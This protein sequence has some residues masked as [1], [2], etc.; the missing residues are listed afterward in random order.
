MSLIEQINELFNLLLIIRNN[1]YLFVNTALIK[2]ND[3]V[4]LISDL[5]TYKL[6]LYQI[7]YIDKNTAEVVKK[8]ID[9]INLITENISN[10]YDEF[11]LS[12]KI[13]IDRIKESCDKLIKSSNVTL[14]LKNFTR[15]LIFFAN[16]YR[17]ESENI[18]EIIS[19]AEKKFK[20]EEYPESLDILI[21]LLEKI[22]ISCETND[23]E[24]I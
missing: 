20:L 4:N 12:T 6:F 9:S 21:D 13:E 15:N 5:S 7:L 3:Y 22:K 8:N 17:N 24:F 19:L 23:I 2:Y 11:Y 18:D 10:N 14:T 1:I 16:K